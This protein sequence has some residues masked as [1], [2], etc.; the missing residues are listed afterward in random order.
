MSQYYRP[1]QQQNMMKQY[2][3][4]EA[5]IAQ[6]ETPVE[7]DPVIYEE[8]MYENDQEA[9]AEPIPEV[10]PV[11]PAMTNEQGEVLISTIT[12]IQE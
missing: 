7:E 4:Q 9:Y 2:E 11:E 10:A 3:V 8:P 5:A 1:A 12:S 6:P